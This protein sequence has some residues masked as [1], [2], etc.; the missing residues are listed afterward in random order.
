MSVCACVCDMNKKVEKYKTSN[1]GNR[2]YT[3]AI[4]KDLLKAQLSAV[5]YG[6]GGWN[7]GKILSCQNKT[8]FV[9]Y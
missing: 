1:S 2:K 9:F 3:E 8:V 6:V 7:N 4:T 5:Y